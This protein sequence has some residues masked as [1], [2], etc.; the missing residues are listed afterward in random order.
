MIL[1]DEAPVTKTIP[2][3]TAAEAVEKHNL[4][5]IGRT[6][7]RSKLRAVGAGHFIRVF[8]EEDVIDAKGKKP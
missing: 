7:I 6:G 3:I 5:P 2:W 8:H 1:D 4:D